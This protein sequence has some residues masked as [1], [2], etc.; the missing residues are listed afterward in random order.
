[1]GVEI[2]LLI[3]ARLLD[4]DA[5]LK[6]LHVSSNVKKLTKFTNCEF[7]SEIQQR[8]FS[9]LQTRSSMRSTSSLAAW[10]QWSKSSI[11]TQDFT[12]QALFSMRSWARAN[13]FAPDLLNK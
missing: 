4:Q 1:M 6:H 13:F 2:E 5:R 9:S 7:K 3:N 10:H 12:I 8:Y 11:L